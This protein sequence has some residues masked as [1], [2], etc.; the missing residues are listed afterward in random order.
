MLLVYVVFCTFCLNVIY[1]FRFSSLVK[2]IIFSLEVMVPKEAGLVLLHNCAYWLMRWICPS[3]LSL[4]KILSQVWVHLWR[5]M[6]ISHIKMHLVNVCFGH[7]T[8]R[9]W[10]LISALLYLLCCFLA[11]ENPGS[12]NV[13]SSSV[14]PPPTVIDRV[15]KELFQEGILLSKSILLSFVYCLIL[16]LCPCVPLLTGIFFFSCGPLTG[17]LLSY[18]GMNGFLPHKFIMP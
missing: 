4:W 17:I 5:T 14:I 13:K 15:L 8:W 10:L 1:L 18:L 9:W 7:I 16:F 11:V 12:D 3:Q 6:C 2:M